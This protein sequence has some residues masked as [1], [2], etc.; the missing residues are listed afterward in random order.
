M[1]KLFRYF[2]GHLLALLASII[3][4]ILVIVLE[5]RQTQ[6]IGE[7]I[8][9]GISTGNTQVIFSTGFKMIGLAVLG[10]ILG[11]GSTYLASYVSNHFGH[12]MRVAIY[13]KIQ[14]FS[15]KKTSKYSTGSLITRLST[16]VDFIQRLMLF[17]VRMLVRAPIMLFSAVIMIYATEK[18]LAL[19]VLTFVVLLFIGL[20]FIILK[21]FPRFQKLQIKI[22]NLNQKIQESL[23]NI[24]V[25]KSFVREEYQDQKFEQVN[26]ELKDQ[27]IYASSLMLWIDPIMM[28]SLNLAT[29]VIMWVGGN[30]IISNDG[31]L[32]GDLLV[33]LNFMRH[34]L[35][36]MMMLTMMFMMYSRGR[37]SSDRINEILEEELDIKN[38]ET[39]KTISNVTGHLTYDSVDFKFF[40]E[41]QQYI[42]EDI[43]FE[44]APGQQLGVIGGTGSGKSTLIN[45]LTRLIEPIDG[46]IL[47]DGVNILDLS[48]EQLREIVGVVPQKNVLFSGSIEYNLKW[49]NPE[50]SMEL[51]E[52]ATKVASIYDF[53]ME[54]E[55]GFQ[56]RIAQG[57]SNLSG[58]QRQRMCIA[59][60][61]VAQPKI[62]VLDDSTSALDATT[63]ANI[64]EAFKTQLPEV[65]IIN[66]AQKISSIIH[67]DKILVLDEGRICGVGTHEELLETCGIYNDIYQSQLKGGDF[68]E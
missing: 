7:I 28:L 8:N 34:T 12:K 65:S 31:L 22:D 14:R 60:A 11:L 24:R 52:W 9:L 5:L 67:C 53:I 20:I 13:E 43:S 68:D 59:R 63:E 25:I 41:N 45:L 3:C 40:K 26:N 44:L 30:I 56:Y 2:K 36:S 48:L 61:L 39:I 66:I 47:I 58:G 64:N 62:L 16:D 46:Q 6:M 1:I 37:A 57:G 18:R 15:L 23:I 19:V 35:F 17:G 10:M 4:T 32:V 42:L 21:G 55:E 54:Q 51:L 38:K 29:I 27:G 49:G 50:A 33:F